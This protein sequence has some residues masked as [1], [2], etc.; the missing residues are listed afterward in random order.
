MIIAAR[1]LGEY[2][3]ERNDETGHHEAVFLKIG[4][5]DIEAGP[6]GLRKLAKFLNQ[7]ARHMEKGGQQDHFH[8]NA[9]INDRPQIV[10]LNKRIARE[11]RREF[12]QM[13]AEATTRAARDAD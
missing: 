11:R 9:N 7:C 5:L 2:E 10:V 6:K 8:Y 13:A 3:A 12:E 1:E 4:E